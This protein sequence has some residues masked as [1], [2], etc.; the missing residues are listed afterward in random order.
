MKITVRD[1]YQENQRQTAEVEVPNDETVRNALIKSGHDKW[2]FSPLYE[3]LV[4]GNIGSLETLLNPGDHVVHQLSKKGIKAREED[5]RDRPWVYCELPE[6][7]F[8]GVI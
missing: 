8:T 2:Y 4:N 1:Y 5:M 3:T 7:G 6:S